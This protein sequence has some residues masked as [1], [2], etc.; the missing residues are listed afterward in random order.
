LSSRPLSVEIEIEGL[1]LLGDALQNAPQT[2]D[3]ALEDANR[4]ALGILGPAVDAFTRVDTGFMV[5]NN[6]FTVE[7]MFTVMYTNWTPYVGIWEARDRFVE[8]GV[9][10][11]QGEVEEIYEDAMDDVARTFAGGR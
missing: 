7:G 5:S 6:E 9:E 1:S 3:R 2:V 10:S 11:V 8:A 4:E